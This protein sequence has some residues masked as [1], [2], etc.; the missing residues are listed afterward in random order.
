MLLLLAGADGIICKA[1]SK[2]AIIIKHD[3]IKVV[4]YSPSDVAL[5][6]VSKSCETTV[7]LLG[8]QE[9]PYYKITSLSS[10]GASPSVG[11]IIVP[12]WEF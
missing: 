7:F 2:H 5:H 10:P 6:V 12:F 11:T 3:G 4:S 1:G 8:L 9:R